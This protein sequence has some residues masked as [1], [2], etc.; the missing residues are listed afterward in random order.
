MSTE[1]H[2]KIGN[3][4]ALRGIA[5]LLVVFAHVGS[6]EKR[7]FDGHAY[8]EL[9]TV[10]GTAG[11][12]LFFVISGFVMMAICRGRFQ[13]RNGAWSFLLRRVVRIYPLYWVFTL[14]YLPI[15]LLH[16]EMM[17][18]QEGAEGVSLLRSFLLLPG[19]QAPLV[20]QA[21]TLV[22]EMYF[23]LVFSL[24][25]LF[26]ERHKLRFLALWSGLI[27]LVGTIASISGVLRSSPSLI[28]VTDPL[29]FEFIAG[30]LA[31]VLV[32]KHYPLNSGLLVALGIFG[33]LLPGL[34]SLPLD[35]TVHLDRMIMCILP[36]TFLVFGAVN[37]EERNG[38]LFPKVLRFTGDISYSVY[39]SHMIVVSGAHKL[40]RFLDLGSSTAAHLFYVALSVGL[41]CAAGVVIYFLVE[42]PLLKIG[43]AAV[44]RVLRES[45]TAKPPIRVPV[46][47]R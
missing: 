16:P 31:C 34:I 14:L 30:C 33:L 26:P 7:F 18:R 2:Q 10:I 38:I 40:F 24:A 23:Y 41:A 19:L 4:Q 28:L 1:E 29:T 12:D 45:G 8:L 6:Y 15:F 37:L 22:H 44:R 25:L 20:G 47:Q 32:P 42:R 5:V 43:Y 11:V 21:W 17:N 36:A 27:I 46:E 3:I 9:F 13:K 39:L 35:R